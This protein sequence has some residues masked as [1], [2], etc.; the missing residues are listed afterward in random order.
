MLRPATP[1]PRSASPLARGQND[2]D[3]AAE[4][5]VEP[6]GDE[7]KE[8]ASPASPAAMELGMEVDAST[9]E[10]SEGLEE[11]QPSPPLPAPVERA[12]AAKRGAPGRGAG[13]LAK[14]RALGGLAAMQ[15]QALRSVAGGMLLRHLGALGWPPRIVH[16]G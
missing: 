1:S 5:P 16:C 2:A 15:P 12:G 11:R 4:R 7:P 8:P 13:P 14:R 9:P 10:A 6:A 3:V